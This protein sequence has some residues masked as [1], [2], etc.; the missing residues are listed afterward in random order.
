M[1]ILVVLYSSGVGK[2]RTGTWSGISYGKVWFISMFFWFEID[3]GPGVL[4]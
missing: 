1:V 2:T 4:W 3:W